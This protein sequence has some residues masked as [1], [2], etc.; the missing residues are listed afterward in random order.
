[1]KIDYSTGDIVIITDDNGNKCCI[2]FNDIPALNV[3]LFE[4]MNYSVDSFELWKKAAKL[5]DEQHN[6]WGE[7]DDD[8]D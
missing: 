1:M 4:A 8:Y 5:S 2:N 6:I 7:N 3:A